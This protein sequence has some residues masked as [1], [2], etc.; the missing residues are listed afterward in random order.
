MKTEDTEVL[1]DRKLNQARSKPDTELLIPLCTITTVHNTACNE[2][3][4]VPR[5][6]GLVMLWYSRV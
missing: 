6:N 2:V 1:E 5:L 3:L 4:L